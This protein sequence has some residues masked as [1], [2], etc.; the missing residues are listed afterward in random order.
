MAPNVTEGLLLNNELP[1]LADRRRV[2]KETLES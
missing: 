2:E 1:K